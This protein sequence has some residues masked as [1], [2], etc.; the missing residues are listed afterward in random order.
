MRFLYNLGKT[1]VKSGTLL[2]NGAGKEE[3]GLPQNYAHG[4]GERGT[5]SGTER[6]DVPCSLGCEEPKESVCGL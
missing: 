4:S 3:R 2:M 5:C 6:P 1:L